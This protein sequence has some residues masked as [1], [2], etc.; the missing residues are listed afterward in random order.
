MPT[1]KHNGSGAPR[2]IEQG[3][4]SAVQRAQDGFVE[5]YQHI[6]E[7]VRRSPGSSLAAAAVAGYL[8]RSIP[9]GALL[10]GLF[11]LAAALLRPALF[12]Y[13]AAKLYD[14]LQQQAAAEPPARREVETAKATG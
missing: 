13:V 2:S 5:E 1:R 10:S 3:I 12:L 6:E 9:V 7:V 4:A 14:L 8:A 11:R